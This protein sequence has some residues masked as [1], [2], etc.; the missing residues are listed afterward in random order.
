MKT[1][2]GIPQSMRALLAF[3]ICGALLAGCAEPAPPS[4]SIAELLRNPAEHALADGLRNY[5]DGAFEKA[6]HDLRTAIRMGLHDRRDTGEAYKHLAF[7][8][9]AFNRPGECEA[10]FRAAFAS[11]PGFQLSEAEVGHPI[12]GPVYR[13]VKASLPASAKGN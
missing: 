1:E 9:C 6:E 12:W 3:T 10:D 5:D 13:R 2:S 8:D 7:I 4:V 11:D